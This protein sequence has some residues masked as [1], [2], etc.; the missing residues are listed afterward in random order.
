VEPIKSN[1]RNK[2]REYDIEIMGFDTTLSGN[3]CVKV[4][5]VVDY[6]VCGCAG[7]C[8]WWGVVEV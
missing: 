8:G 5:C 2:W 7:V 4:G 1:V 6:G 3:R